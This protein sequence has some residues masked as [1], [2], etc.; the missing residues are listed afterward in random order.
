MLE[1][2]I[3]FYISALMHGSVVSMNERSRLLRGSMLIFW[4]A[5]AIIDC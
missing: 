2:K 4:E 1:T 5:L 3:Y